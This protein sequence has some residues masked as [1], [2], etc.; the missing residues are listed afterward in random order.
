MVVQRTILIGTLSLGTLWAACLVA[1]GLWAM[2]GSG[3]ETWMLF[4]AGGAGVAAGNFVFMEVVADRLL[5]RARRGI[6]D[7]V[8]LLVA[9][10]ILVC[11]GC[12]GYLWFSATGGPQ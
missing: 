10:A 6:V 1:T 11:L 9:L 12:A 4:W 5:P 3:Q 8:E 2:G 7:A